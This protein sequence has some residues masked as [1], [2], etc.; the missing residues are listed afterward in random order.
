M[1][2]DNTD[3]MIGSGQFTH[4]DGSLQAGNDHRGVVLFINVLSDLLELNAVS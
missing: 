1:S 2:D 4:H 3:I